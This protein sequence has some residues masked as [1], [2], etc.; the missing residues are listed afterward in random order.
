MTV[1]HLEGGG[2]QAFIIA[3]TTIKTNVQEIIIYLG[4]SFFCWDLLPGNLANPLPALHCVDAPRGGYGSWADTITTRP[5]L[6]PGAHSAAKNLANRVSHATRRRPAN[7]WNDFMT[8]FPNCWPA[9]R[10]SFL[11]LL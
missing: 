8:F 10:L 6:P 1:G 9:F 5:L 7:K 3:R 11:F 2:G 4:S